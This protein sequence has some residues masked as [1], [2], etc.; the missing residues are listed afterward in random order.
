MSQE[1]V[2]V[3]QEAYKFWARGELPFE[4]SHPN[5]RMDN[6]KEWVMPGPFYGHEGL[7]RWWAET[8]E[9]LP[10]VRLSLVDPIEVGDACVVG[11]VRVSGDSRDPD[12]IEAF[13]TFSATH[14]VEE[15]LI[16]RVAGFLTR[17]EALEAARLRE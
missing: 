10:G 8:V 3:V 17:E 13:G 6:I 11:E 9:A 12:L 7:R 2:E 15:G 14:W 4:V 5:I 1:N 16:I